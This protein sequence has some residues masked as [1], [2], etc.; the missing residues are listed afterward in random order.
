MLLTA[1]DFCEGKFYYS[2]P[3]EM[4]YFTLESTEYDD[5]TEPFCEKLAGDK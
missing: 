3:S 4:P 1:V 5:I 2:N